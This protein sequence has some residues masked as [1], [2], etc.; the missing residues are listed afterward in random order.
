MKTA[1]YTM[2]DG[3]KKEFL[4][5]ENAACIVCLS[6]DCGEFRD[7][8]KWTSMNPEKIKREAKLKNIKRLKN[9][10]ITNKE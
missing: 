9:I 1:T 8:S 5:D 6:C 7:G 3:S 10:K 4:Y 2:S